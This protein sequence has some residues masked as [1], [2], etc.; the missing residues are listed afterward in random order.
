M[1]SLPSAASPRNED[2]HNR[3]LLREAATVTG[4]NMGFK[5]ALD[6]FYLNAENALK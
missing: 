1:A 6:I 3:G 4:G 5:K 2:V